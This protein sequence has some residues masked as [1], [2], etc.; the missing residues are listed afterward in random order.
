MKTSGL[1]DRAVCVAALTLKASL[2][3]SLTTTPGVVEQG[4]FSKGVL[5]LAAP[6]EDIQLKPVASHR[7]KGR[8]A[9]EDGGLEGVQVV[10]VNVGCPG[11]GG[12]PL[13][14]GDWNH[15]VQTAWGEATERN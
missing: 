5:L 10:F 7:S 8:R 9:D 12:S 2:M 14:E 6:G 13:G 4:E 11:G 1:V 3:F 15:H